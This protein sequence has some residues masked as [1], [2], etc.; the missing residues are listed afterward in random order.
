MYRHIGVCPH[1][2]VLCV[3]ITNLLFMAKHMNIKTDENP[4]EFTQVVAIKFP[5]VITVC[6]SDRCYSSERVIKYWTAQSQL[7]V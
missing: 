6:K 1:M 2:Q 4:P 5:V 3:T 7:G